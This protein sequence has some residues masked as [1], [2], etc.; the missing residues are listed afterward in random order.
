MDAA[1]WAGV[2]CALTGVLGSFIEWQLPVGKR[3]Q[4]LIYWGLPVPLMLWVA[5][6]VAGWWFSAD[7]LG[8]FESANGA[9]MSNEVKAVLL[10]GEAVFAWRFLVRT[11][12]AIIA[13]YARGL[14]WKVLNLFPASWTNAYNVALSRSGRD[15]YTWE[16]D[17]AEQSEASSLR[18]IA[19]SLN[20]LLPREVGS[21]HRRDYGQYL[22]PVY[23]ASDNERRRV[24]V[25]AQRGDSDRPFLVIRVEQSDYGVKDASLGWK[26]Y[27][28][29][30]D[31][32]EFDDVRRFLQEVIDDD[33][34]AM[35]NK[36]RKA[37][38]PFR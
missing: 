29:L 2:G 36:F 14:L 33:T 18:K 9:G 31:E 17:D 12:L 35:S 16:R 8:I 25:E 28:V 21:G 5:A 19:R 4:K 11:P 37:Q 15:P 34:D 20:R 26:E 24:S 13:G 10:T 3:V 1:A 38:R 32:K 30:L 7:A 22:L 27:G 6:V 23:W